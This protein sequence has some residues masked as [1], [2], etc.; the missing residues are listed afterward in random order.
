MNRNL[1]KSD[2]A[3]EAYTLILILTIIIFSTFPWS[4]YGMN[5]SDTSQIFH[6]GNRIVNG[7]FP[8]RDFDYQTGFIGIVLDAFFQKILGKTYLSSLVARFLV[9]VTTLLVLYLTF[10]QF[11][12]RFISAAN[13]SGLALFNPILFGGGNDN[14]VN[15]FLSI[16]IFFII[17]G[18]Q[19][20]VKKTSFIYFTI[21]GF[22]LA[23][24]VGARQSNGIICI[25]VTLGVILAYSLTD[26][27]K[28]IIF[29]A[30][31]VAGIIV[32]LGSIIAILVLNSALY[33]AFDELFFT[34]AEKKNVSTI[35]S[36]IDA[37]SGGLNS[38]SSIKEILKYVVI[39]LLVS[40]GIFILIREP[41][42]SL[43][44][45]KLNLNRLATVAIPALLIFGIATNKFVG[46]GELLFYDLPRTFFSIALIASCVFPKKS[47]LIL[48]LPHPIF[49]LLI[50][51]TLGTTW[52]MQISWPGRPYIYNDMLVITVILT[53][54]MSTKICASWK[55]GLSL[56]FL[57]VTVSIFFSNL[58]SHSLGAEGNYYYGFYKDTNYSLNQPMTKFIKVTKEKAKTFYMLHQNINIGDSCFIYGSA[59]V[60]YS[61]LQCN[62]PTRLDLTNSDALTLNSAIKT[63]SSLRNTP[64][65]WIIDTGK[66]GFYIQ[67]IFNGSRNF[68]GPFNQLGSKELHTGLQELINDYQLV[69]T[70]K[71][72]FSRKEK[73]ESRDHDQVIRFRLYKYSRELFDKNEII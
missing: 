63:V 45:N 64:P 67:D 48:G 69:N 26:L 30:P 16:S 7:D 71:D 9:K 23:L 27:K 52:A 53:M 3:R 32:G 44:N 17:I 31:F 25:A 62:N 59:S 13:C 36:L 20:I 12:S 28:L 18:F 43:P 51:L 19:E 11:T 65:K 24:V 41:I 72:M 61:I 39:P 57:A 21:S 46:S 50:A 22:S 49:P 70:V 14:Y 60:L 2:Q 6:F 4:L 5:W 1:G 38:D 40:V 35:I 42:K 66:G 29:I 56:A 33:E 58:V 34:A 10:R 37:F 54:L 68:Y 73:L 55:R 47:Q 8:Y 15:L